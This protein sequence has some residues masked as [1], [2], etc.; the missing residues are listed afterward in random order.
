[1]KY[2][3]KELKTYSREILLDIFIEEYM[4]LKRVTDLES[5]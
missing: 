1:M 5:M 3:I 4:N 2:K